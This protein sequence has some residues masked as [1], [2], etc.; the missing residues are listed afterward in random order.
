MNNKDF[1]NEVARQENESLYLKPND[2]T[3]K[4]NI[5]PEDSGG[6]D[7]G[8]GHKITLDDKTLGNIYGFPFKDGVT[9]EVALGI[10]E[11]DIQKHMILTRAFV[12]F[13]RFE[14]LPLVAQQLLCD[15]SFTGVLR[16][17]PKFVM[18]IFDKNKGGVLANYKRYFTYGGKRKELVRRNE[19]AFKLIQELTKEGYFGN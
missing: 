13:E 4:P 3:V 17:F 9:K 19:F 1:R 2:F 8:F 12:G 14:S 10:L 5:A 7:I 18:S 15:Y 11:M 6:Y 16:K